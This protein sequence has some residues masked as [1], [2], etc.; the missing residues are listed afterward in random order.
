[1]SSRI[2]SFME[3]LP[4]NGKGTVSPLV[5]P[6]QQRP[7]IGAADNATAMPEDFVFIYKRLAIRLRSVSRQ[8]RKFFP[9]ERGANANSAF[10]LRAFLVAPRGHPGAFPDR[11]D[12]RRAGLG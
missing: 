10:A 6:S 2:E 7:P 12:R 1:M 11:C 5:E 8:A 4:R 9:S 3:N